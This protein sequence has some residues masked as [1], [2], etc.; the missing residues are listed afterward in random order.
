MTRRSIILKGDAVNLLT[1]QRGWQETAGVLGLFGDRTASERRAYEEFVEKGILQ[2]TRMLA[3]L[4]V[5]AI[6]VMGVIISGISMGPRKPGY[7]PLKTQQQS[8]QLQT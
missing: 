5:V 3:A 7:V 6:V 4:S 2:G 8:T 1:L